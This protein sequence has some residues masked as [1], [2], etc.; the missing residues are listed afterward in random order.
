MDYDYL[1]PLTWDIWAAV[2][3]LVPKY[4]IAKEVEMP[5]G[6]KN[7]FLPSA[8][9]ASFLLNSRANWLMDTAREAIAYL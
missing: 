3:P 8:D 7:I 4:T 9:S 5:Q 1:F 6:E 2:V